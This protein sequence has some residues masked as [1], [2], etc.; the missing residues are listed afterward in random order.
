MQSS[1]ELSLLQIKI[2]KIFNKFKTKNKLNNKVII[3][4]SPTNRSLL[5]L[6]LFQH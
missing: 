5:S 6:T 1:K 3:I 4:K 2:T